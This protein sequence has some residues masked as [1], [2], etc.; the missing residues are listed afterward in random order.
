MVATP[1]LSFHHF[2]Y[3]FGSSSS[4]VDVVATHTRGKTTLHYYNKT[5]YKKRP[6]YFVDYI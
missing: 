3:I 4:V 6:H 1:S 2:P 5:Y